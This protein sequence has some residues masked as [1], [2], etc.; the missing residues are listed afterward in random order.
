MAGQNFAAPG[1]TNGVINNMPPNL[2]GP[3][4]AVMNLIGL[5][6][7]IKEKPTTD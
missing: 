2:T 3:V 5:V 6:G 4:A 7:K 1:I